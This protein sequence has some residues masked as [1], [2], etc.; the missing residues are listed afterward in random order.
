MNKVLYL[1]GNLHLPQL[2]TDH[3]P[4][5]KAHQ[6][7]EFYAY[8]ID[9]IYSMKSRCKTSLNGWTQIS[10]KT[11]REVF[12]QNYKPSLN[13]L[14]SHGVVECDHSYFVGSFP[15]GYRIGPEYRNG[16]RPIR[17]RVPSLEFVLD[18]RRFH[19]TGGCQEISGSLRSV[20]ESYGSPIG[21]NP[22]RIRPDLTSPHN[23]TT[24]VQR[25]HN[26]EPTEYHR[27]HHAQMFHDLTT[28]TID[29]AA[30]DQVVTEPP[31]AAT[32]EP[33]KSGHCR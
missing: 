21:R 11:F 8:M 27:P 6:S 26:F 23:V 3:P 15:K 4:P 10:Y 12:G 9:L 19:S 31:N 18:R 5:P 28:V 16:D 2:L 22:S 1:P 25:I 20:F 24:H 33:L 17:L 7:W 29:P 30:F 32:P 14:L 13:Y